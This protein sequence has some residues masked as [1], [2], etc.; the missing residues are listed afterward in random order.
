MTM[1][2]AL[3]LLLATW[4][5][6]GCLGVFARAAGA[7]DW[8]Y[9]GGGSW[10]DPTKWNGGIPD[11]VDAV[12]N[13][14]Q[15]TPNGTDND[16]IITNATA[17]V[18]TLVLRD[19]NSHDNSG[20]QFNSPGTLTFDVSSGRALINFRESMSEISI[21]IVLM[22]D[23]DITYTHTLGG[24]RANLN[25]S[26]SSG[27]GLTTHIDINRINP[28]GSGTYD[29]VVW[30]GNNTFNGNV[31]IHNGNLQ[32]SGGNAIPNA[33]DLEIK[34]GAMLTLL[35]T[36]EAINALNGAGTVR[37]HP[38]FA[39]TLTVGAN[40]GNGTFSG[41]IRDDGSG[42]TSFAKTGSGTQVLS[43]ANTYTGGTTINQGTLQLGNDNVLPDTG[44]INVNGG[45]LDVNTRNDTV[46]A[47]TLT[48]GSITGTTGVL[49]GSSYTVQ[50]GTI[51]AI[52]GGSGTL[53]KTTT[54]TVTLA[55]ANTYSG[56]TTVSAGTLLLGSP[57][58][59]GSGTSAIQLCDASTGAS[60]VA[61]LT[62]VWPGQGNPAAFPIARNIVVN[63]LGTGKV[64][65]GSNAAGAGG[66]WVEFNGSITMNKDLHLQGINV[67]R[68]TF[69][70]PI[71]GT[72]NL[73]IDG[74]NRITF[75]AN[76]TYNGDTYITA[77]MAQLQGGNAIPNTSNVTVQSGAI[78]RI[79]DV[80]EAINGL[81]GAGYVQIG[82]SARTLTVGAAGG[83]GSFSGVLR[84]EGTGV[85]S[86]VKAGSGTQTLSGTNTYTGTTTVSAGTLVLANA[87]ALGSATSAVQLCD[88]NTGASD[89]ALLIDGN[90]TISRDI[91][92]NNL[93]TGTVTIGSISAGGLPTFGGTITLGRSVQLKGVAGDRTSFTGVI[94]GN[95]DITVIGPNRVFFGA[96]NTYNGNT[97]IQAGD[98]QVNTGDGI[99]NT[100]NVTV[101]SG[102]YF[103]L[104]WASE[105]INGLF[106]NGVVRPHPATSSVTLTVGAAG[107]DGDF[108]GV[109]R[110]EGGKVMSLTKTGAGAQVLGGIN[111]YT[112]PTTVLAGTLRVNGSIANSS[113]TVAAGATLAGG[114]T[115]GPVV[116][117]GIIAPGNSTGTLTTGSQTWNGGAAY[118][119]EINDV[120]APG[121]Q[122]GDPGWDWL[123]INGTLDIA[124]TGANPFFI[125]VT[126]LALDGSP[127]P[128]H[129][130][131]LHREGA[132]VIATASGGV[133]NFAVEK[134]NV[135]T[136]H[137]QNSLMGSFAVSLSSD[138][139]SIMLS[140]TAPEPGGAAL[141]GLGLLALIGAVLRRRHRLGD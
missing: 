40:G 126:S 72:G 97:F 28:W 135:L 8:N 107:G 48:S 3:R 117:D 25:G 67:D 38:G 93:G 22:D 122:G 104:A 130:F 74:P 128:V 132:W 62:D 115:T 102:A 55:A 83:S 119:W 24:H 2:L 120:D 113:I 95:G 100:S 41:V 33:S 54:G 80:S 5:A 68:T 79:W 131:S 129:D 50:S 94:T 11:A 35:T 70:G 51:S 81:N 139:K 10:T 82:N 77:G 12:A 123:N 136:N 118:L 1:R 36:N 23:L 109:I 53:T 14:E 96:N 111:A 30:Y 18:G 73:Y 16:F 105:A 125:D 32:I 7:S 64:T 76:N 85:L 140:Y 42:V 103:T 57:A 4:V 121:G 69:N 21:P 65:I 133:T 114:G 29:R 60:D 59:M 106:G 71:S 34:A 99:P 87:S 78:L 90:Y 37:T 20:W 141:L 92:V 58:A 39:G 45:T 9:A 19:T 91:N 47:V 46:G 127:G 56:V 98:L 6:I 101:Q 75:A 137:F 110:D 52:L 27:M 108:G 17:T 26:I 124:A 49:T 116:L 112:G 86:L 13:F 15:D 44:A 88:A 43:G 66:K 138:Q 63:N 61:L 31:T 84:N 134:F 89:V